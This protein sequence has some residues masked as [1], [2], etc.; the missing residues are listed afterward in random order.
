MPGVTRTLGAAG[1]VDYSRVPAAVLRRRQLEG[2]AVHLATEFDDAGELDES[3]CSAYVMSC[4]RAWRMWRR[5]AGFEVEHC[6]RIVYGFT[7][8]G[9]FAGTTDRCGRLRGW[10]ATVEIKTTAQLHAE[11]CR[12]QTAAYAD[13]A[14]QS[15]GFDAAV[16]V[17]VQLRPDGTFRAELF[18]DHFDRDFG[19]FAGA[20]AHVARWRPMGGKDSVSHWATCPDAGRWRR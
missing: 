9:P 3:T 2:R 19:R 15:I 6:E 4:V 1:V 17:A 14:R 8:A 13:A 18:D 11:A 12:M 16:R 10:R 20:L 5:L 7:S